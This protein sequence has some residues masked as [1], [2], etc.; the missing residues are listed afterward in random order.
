MTHSIEHP[1]STLSEEELD[2]VSG[3]MKTDPNYV[4]KNVI[5]ARGGSL[6]VWGVTFTYDINGKMSS[7][8]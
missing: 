6:T 7:I 5:D 4:S 1:V 8:S 3:G 2:T